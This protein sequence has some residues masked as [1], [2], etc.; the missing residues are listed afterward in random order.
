MELSSAEN[1]PESF[2]RVTR[3]HSP[4]PHPRLQRGQPL[5]RQDRPRQVRQVPGQL[6]QVDRLPAHRKGPRRGLDLPR[7]P[8][9]PVHHRQS[10]GTGRVQDLPHLRRGPAP[11][12]RLRGGGAALPTDLLQGL[13]HPL[14]GVAALLPDRDPRLGAGV[15]PNQRSPRSTSTAKSTTFR[16]TSF[17]GATR[18]TSPSWTS[19]ASSSASF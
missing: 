13:P 19:T 16:T 17:R 6:P 11:V 15:S 4:G 14:Q 8:R 1:I 12:P 5:P 10:R 2:G 9:A 7:L 3:V 18:C